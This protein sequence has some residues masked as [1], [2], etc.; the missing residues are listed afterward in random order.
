MTVCAR[1]T[2]GFKIHKWT[3]EEMPYRLETIAEGLY[4]PWAIAISDN[5]KIYF[6]ERSGNLR[7]IDKGRLVQEP[8]ITFGPPFV[9]RGEGGLMG[10]VLDPNFT[11]NHYIYV[12]QTYTEHNQLYNRVIRLKED[13]D[14]AQIDQIIIDKIPGG[15]LHNGGRIKIGP[16]QKLYVTTGDTGNS[17]TSQ[18]M[19][20]LAGKILRLELDGSI[21]SDNPIPNSP[22]YSLGHRNPQGLAWNAEDVLYA[23]DHGPA[24]H[25]EINIIYPGANYGWPY[26]EGDETS[27]EFLIQNPIIQSGNITWAPSGMTFVKEGPWNGQLLVAALRGEELLDFTIDDNGIDVKNM[28]SWLQNQV[29]RLRE[30]VEDKDGIIYIATSNRDGRGAPSPTDDKI[31]QLVP[32]ER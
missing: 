12:M 13:N 26:V 27:T 22:I 10:I 5:G 23:S 7:V 3:A 17:N 14:T 21:P 32:K 31:I 16:D 15:I 11:Q 25:D 6:T 29:G 24:G 9:N 18:D 1:N 4:V 2:V 8:L 28:A 19:N 30:V 20:S